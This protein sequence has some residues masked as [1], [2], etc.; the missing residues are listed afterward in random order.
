[1]TSG[2]FEANC[3]PFFNSI[4]L[5]YRTNHTVVVIAPGEGINN[6]SRNYAGKDND[7]YY[8]AAVIIVI[9]VILR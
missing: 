5:S 7:K 1:M 9:I 2:S 6:R 3:P 8:C 4:E